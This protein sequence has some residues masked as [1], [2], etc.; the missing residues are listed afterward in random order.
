MLGTSLDPT[1]LVNGEPTFEGFKI[2]KEKLPS[3]QIVFCFEE[4]GTSH[5]RNYA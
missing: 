4:E 3:F 2:S 1:R 5:R